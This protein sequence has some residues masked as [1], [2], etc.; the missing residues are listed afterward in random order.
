MARKIIIDTDPG[1]DDAM[2]IFLAL[3][4]PELELVG[5]TTVFGNSNVDATT[6]NALNLLHVA[7]RTDIPVARGA[8]RPLVNPPGP[9]GEWVHGEDAMGNIGWTTVLDPA[10]KPV[11][12]PAARFIV[13]T[14]MANPGE[15]T[16]VPIGPLT[17]LALALQ[18]EPRIA[19]H[20][21]EIVMMGGSA[22]APGNVSPL[23]E[24]NV[25]NDPHAASVV[26]SAD[27]PITMAGLDVTESI[28]MDDAHFGALATSSDP[29]GLF[30]V[31]IVGFYQ[32]FHR[33]WYGMVNGAIHTH[34][35]CA[36]LYLLDPTL[37]SGERW[38][39]TVPHD[40]PAKGATLVDRRGHFYKTPPV[41]CLLK[42]DAG[43]LVGLYLERM[44]V[45]R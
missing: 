2:A 27:W 35:A 38:P 4:S 23:A 19:T 1:V 16:L 25:H 11:D 24:A 5:L 34:D 39:I 32:T 33:D 6:R 26:F 45:S 14:I 13:D 18:L 31:K 8:G 28:P 3:R 21:R 43:R 17:N 10:L 29:L 36:I 15:I 37:F 22:L 12:V 7:G 40:G 20:V 42:V 44:G 9:T 41:H 30:I